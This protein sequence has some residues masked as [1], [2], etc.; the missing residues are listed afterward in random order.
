MAISS[1]PQSLQDREISSGLRFRARFY[2]FAASFNLHRL[3]FMSGALLILAGAAFGL[4]AKAENAPV[5][6]AVIVVFFGMPHGAFDAV[7]FSQAWPKDCLSRKQNFIVDYVCVAALVVAFWAFNPGESL[8][9][10]L[11]V[12]ALHFSGDWERDIPYLTRII[13]GASLLAFPALFHEQSVRWIFQWLVPAGDAASLAAGLRTCALGL[14]P[15]AAAAIALNLRNSP[16]ATLEAAI[17]LALAIAATPL[18]FFLAYFCG[19]HSIRHLLQVRET[20]NERMAGSLFALAFPYAL[21]AAL[22]IAAGAAAASFSLPLGGAL[23]GSLFI[24][25][26]ALTVPHM[27]FAE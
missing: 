14:L 21:A 3:A 2:P 6:S 25:L 10:F 4:E 16:M 8:C 17:V 9:A 20:L 1:F 27:L 11:A 22:A 26:A 7:L 15:L 23:L 13:V 12:S 5:L 18:T 24:G 19:L